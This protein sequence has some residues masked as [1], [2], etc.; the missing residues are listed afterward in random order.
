[1]FIVSLHTKRDIIV[2]FPSLIYT[3][4]K[5]VLESIVRLYFLQITL[6]IQS[7]Q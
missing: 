7:I 5:T 3:I 6:H 2:P 1:M 4:T